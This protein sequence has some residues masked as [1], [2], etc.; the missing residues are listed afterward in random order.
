MANSGKLI[1]DS[2]KN[3]LA[4]LSTD[5]DVAL[6]FAKIAADSVKN[7]ERRARN[8]D[9]ATTAYKATLHWLGKLHP[10]PEEQREIGGKLDQLRVR[11]K[12]LGATLPAA[13][14]PTMDPE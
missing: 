7:P 12:S 1:D 3:I 10:L 4:V 2:E 6:T 9:N 11:L 14:A 8:I 5:L 13:N